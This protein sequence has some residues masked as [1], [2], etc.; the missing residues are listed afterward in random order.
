[1]S[2]HR[3]LSSCPFNSTI[4]Y[5]IPRK[6]E[7]VQIHATRTRDFNLVVSRIQLDCRFCRSLLGFVDQLV[8]PGFVK[9][10][11]F[12]RGGLPPVMDL[13]RLWTRAIP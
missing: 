3:V 7:E 12:L 5:L 6:L 2:I 8:R 13:S 4:D 1:M 9:F 10:G 11:P